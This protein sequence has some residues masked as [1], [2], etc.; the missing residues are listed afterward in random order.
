MSFFNEADDDDKVRLGLDSMLKPSCEAHS[1]SSTHLQPEVN[2]SALKALFK[3]FDEDG[4][5]KLSKQE[6]VKAFKAWGTSLLGRS[7]R[8]QPQ[9]TH[10][11]MNGRSPHH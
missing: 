4:N 8:P 7:T 2:E 1:F 3:A 5:G 6:L 9:L 11:L 10:S